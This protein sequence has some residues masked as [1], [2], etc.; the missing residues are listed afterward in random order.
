MVIFLLL[1]LS[2]FLY[3]GFQ[4]TYFHRKVLM[5]ISGIGL[6]L[7]FAIYFVDNWEWRKIKSEWIDEYKGKVSSGHNKRVK[8]NKLK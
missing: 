3:F 5:V 1:Q 4:E 8:H 2:P 6:I 7:Y